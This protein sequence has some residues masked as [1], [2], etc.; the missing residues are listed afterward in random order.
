MEAS[1]AQAEWNSKKH[2]DYYS[3]WYPKRMTPNV[4]HNGE[5]FSD[6][7][8]AK[9][10]AMLEGSNSPQARLPVRAVEAPKQKLA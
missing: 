9:Y 1:F 3:C 5:N 7:R 6:N 2:A 8:I 10:P 4:S